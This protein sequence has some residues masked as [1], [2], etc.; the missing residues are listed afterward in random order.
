MQSCVVRAGFLAGFCT[1]FPSS[2]CL[3]RLVF[4]IPCP[5][6]GLCCWDLLIPGDQNFPYKTLQVWGTPVFSGGAL[7]PPCWSKSAARMSGCSGP[8]PRVRLGA[9]L[10]QAPG[11]A[12]RGIACTGSNAVTTTRCTVRGVTRCPGTAGPGTP[13]WPSVL[14]SCHTQPLL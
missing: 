10:D 2:G 4:T 5:S 1:H 6:F 12:H 7:L 14:P 13:Q 9:G 8:C 3:K 11:G